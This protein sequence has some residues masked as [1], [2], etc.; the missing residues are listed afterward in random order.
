MVQI[1]G[2]LFDDAQSP[3]RVPRRL[4]DGARE[5][6]A[7]EPVGAGTGDENPARFKELEGAKVQ[8]LVAARR[9]FYRGTVFRESRWV[10]DNES[11][12]LVGSLEGA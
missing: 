1:L 10:E 5:F 3:P 2:S 7:I 6:F 9:A 11:V 4:F 8:V 12:A